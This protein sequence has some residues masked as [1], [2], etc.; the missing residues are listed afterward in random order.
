MMEEL[1][2]LYYKQFRLLWQGQGT[3]CE[4]TTEVLFVCLKIWQLR[5][6]KSCYF[7]ISNCAPLLHGSSE[8]YAHFHCHQPSQRIVRS[9]T[10]V[11]IFRPIHANLKTKAGKLPP[12]GTPTSIDLGNLEIAHRTPSSGHRLE[13]LHRS[14]SGMGLYANQVL[15][16]PLLCQKI[17]T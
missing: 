4:F 5:K 6:N 7:F 8:L 2:R 16:P 14:R 1:S 9:Q 3:P 17:E 10:K 15:G 13:S 12:V 11:M